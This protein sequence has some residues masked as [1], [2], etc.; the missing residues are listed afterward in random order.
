MPCPGDG[1][2]HEAISENTFF[3]ALRPVALVVWLALASSAQ[4]QDR[5]EPVGPQP[6]RHRVASGLQLGASDMTTPVTVL[7]GDELVCAASDAGRNPGGQPGIASSH[8]GAE[9]QPPHH[10]GMDGPRVKC[11]R[12]RRAARRLHPQPRPRRGLRA[13]LATQIEVLRGPSALVHGDGAVG[14][15]VNVLDGKVPT[16]VPA[17]GLKAAWSCAPTAAPASAGVFSLTGGTGNLAV[18]VEGVARDA[19][20]YRVGPNWV[21]DGHVDLGARQ[22]Q[23][24]RHRQRGHLLGG[25][26]WL[27][28][29]AYRQTAKYG[30][31]G[32]NH[33]F[34][35]CHTHGDHLHCGSHGETT[36]TTTA[37]K[38]NTATCPWW[39]CAASAWTSG[40]AAQP[41]AGFTALRLR[42]GITDYMHDEVED[43][44]PSPPSRTRPTAP[45][46]SCSTN[47]WRAGAACWACRHR[48]AA[49]PPK[50]TRPTSSPPPRARAVCSR[51][52]NTAGATGASGRP[53]PR[54]PDGP[55]RNQWH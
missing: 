15:V 22:L 32:H 35:G 12:R 42:A 11:E 38:T 54:P 52:R 48:T 34:E 14:G 19:A 7:E 8:F 27:P 53:A 51:W 16:A 13:L 47:P 37:M 3:T 30:L 31:P 29:A 17:K 4:A 33:G 46:W 39:T 1:I 6:A 40:R 9:G 44:A 5:S 21:H 43:G 50:A 24:H 25:R 49:L 26:A 28:G 55:G 18:H 45:A 36:A 41:F 2:S 10:P 20:D 23:P